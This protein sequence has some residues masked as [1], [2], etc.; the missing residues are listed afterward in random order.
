MGA[1]YR[2]DIQGLRGISVLLVVLYHTDLIFKGGFIGV[3]VFFVISGYVIMSSLL[4][5]YQKHSSISLKKFISR[6]V[7][8]LLPASSI[9]VIFT[10]ITSI[11]IFSPFSEQGQVARTSI[12]STFFSTN[13]FF[14]LQNSYSALV[15][16]PFRHMWSLGVEEQFYIFLILSISV[17][18]HFSRDKTSIPKR[19]LG[20]VITTG[21][22]SFFANL[23]FAAGIRVLPLPTRIAFFS[24]LT[25]FWELQIGV[26]AAFI[27]ANYLQQLKRSLTAEFLAVCGMFLIFFSALT[28]N[29]FTAFPGPYA[30]GPT[31][32]G[33]CVVLFGNHTRI[34]SL[35]L[36]V[37][38][39]KYLGDISYS[40]YLW[41]WPIIV[42]CQILAPGNQPLLVLSGLLSALPASFSY[43]FIENRF[44]RQN[45]QSSTFPMTI[46]SVSI[47]SQVVVACLVIVG[48][49]T[50]YGLKLQTLTGATGSWAYQAGCQATDP[51]FPI[52][53]CLLESTGATNTVLL[54][55]DSQAG[56]ISDGVKAASESLGVN[57]AV[58]Y[59]DGCPVFPRPTIER[60]DCEPF[61]NALPDLIQR[62]DPSVIVIANKSTLYT[63]GGA[64]RGGLTITK[65]DGELPK[66]YSESIDTWIN[67]LQQQFSSAPFDG[68]RILLVQQVPQ[69][70]PISPTLINRNQAIYTFDINSDPDRNQLIKK[71]FS[72]LSRFKN[73]TL[74]DPAKTICPKDSCLITANG[75]T[76]YS[77]EFHLAP[78]GAL[79]LEHQI[80]EAISILLANP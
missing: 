1:T 13:L 70:K 9:V 64:Q 66:T 44:R 52:K 57:F 6:R 29:S 53:K 19:I 34:V 14:I 59:N 41:H 35:L 23:V 21:L 3:D 24:P 76:L 38:P 48:A 78:Y 69:S 11:F 54:I 49:S 47:I 25:R 22:I 33:L 73:L 51:I 67:G 62:L 17:I 8:R 27:S 4:N 18:F 63:T 80:I 50:T 45:H 60:G 68:E 32:G 30:L 55:G 72:S 75:K 5:E 39:L 20:F 26:I 2:N 46:L 58:W 15:N 61:L 65:P 79:R 7:I 16:N 10:L 36:S 37:K 42:F 12:S 71:E 31:L 77:D 40:W 74:L 56:S 28:L 43:H